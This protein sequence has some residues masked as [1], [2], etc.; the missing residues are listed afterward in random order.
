MTTYVWRDGALVDKA[1]GARVKRDPALPKGRILLA[2]D[3]EG[4]TCPITGAWVEGRKAHR[5]N[6]KR[7]GC[8]VLERGEKEDAR[9]QRKE[10]ERREEQAIGEM[11]ERVAAQL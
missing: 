2:P 3:Y 5:E 8:R 7:H 1:T 6:L 10:N 11:V 9:R 4:Y